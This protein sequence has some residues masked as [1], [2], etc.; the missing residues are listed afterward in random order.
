M[1][2]SCRLFVGTGTFDAAFL[3][4]AALLSLTPLFLQAGFLGAEAQSGFLGA[5]PQSGLL[6]AAPQSGYLGA[7]PQTTFGAP[8]P[9]IPPAKKTVPEACKR[10]L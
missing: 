2:I 9:K 10:C 1:P 3:Q 4:A 7:E 6:G 5:E 8:P